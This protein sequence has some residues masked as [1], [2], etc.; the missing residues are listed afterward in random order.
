MWYLL[1][2]P[3]LERIQYFRYA[4]L[5]IV[6]GLYLV[7]GPNSSDQ[8]TYSLVFADNCAGNFFGG[9]EKGYQYYNMIFGYTNLC[10]YGVDFTACVFYLLTFPLLY[11]YL[12][13]YVSGI[14]LFY[15]ITILS[16]YVVSYQLAYNYRTGMSSMLAILCLLSFRDGRAVSLLY[17]FLS[18]TFHVQA[19][20]IV[21]F[22]LFWKASPKFKLFLFI[23][24]LGL[25]FL[26]SGF[27]KGFI[28]DQGM[29]YLGTYFGSIRISSVMY[30]LVYL[31]CFYSIAKGQL[32]EFKIVLI[33]GLIINL[34]FFFNSHI[35]ARLSRP[36]EPLMMVVFFHSLQFVKFKLAKKLRFIISLMPGILFVVLET[37]I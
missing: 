5:M 25:M 27:F 18:I 16:F 4:I 6:V 7:I 12:K 35:A 37:L 31:F 17:G 8:E 33:F 32:S 24:G 20:P 21:A 26:L 34:L 13:K 19:F 28:L 29:R 3:V 30:I 9:M 22:F 10:Q 2:L 36:I 11:F 1:F 23:F 15:A 14:E